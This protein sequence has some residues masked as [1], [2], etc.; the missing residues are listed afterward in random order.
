MPETEF[1][2]ICGIA[3]SGTTISREIARRAVPGVLLEEPLHRSRGVAGVPVAYPYVSAKGGEYAELIDEITR[4][5]RPWGKHPAS[6]SWGKVKR[7]IF[8][9]AGDEWW[10]RWRLL[11]LRAGLGFAPRRVLWKDPFA[12]LATPY[13]LARH[14][15]RVVCMV[16]HPAAV[17][18]SMCK[19][20]WGFNIAYLRD[21]PELMEAQ[22]C[23]ILPRDWERARASTA[24]SVAILWKVM[25]ALNAPLADADS[26]LMLVRHEDLCDDP[27]TVSRALVKQLGGEMTASAQRFM[28]RSFHGASAE[29]NSLRPHDFVRDIR[30]LG[31]SWRRK[32]SPEDESAMRDIIGDDFHRIYA[33][34]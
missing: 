10:L 7:A 4:F 12:S 20:G 18:V 28:N 16:R 15:A 9:V 14:G 5:A 34:W 23:D 1:R 22:G 31:D 32:V 8:R 29:G 17:Y 13:L 27:M 33:H 6:A 2:V 26:R 11:R 21:Q 30:A 3:R 25:V 24:A 19:W